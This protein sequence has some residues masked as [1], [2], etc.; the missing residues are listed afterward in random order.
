MEDVGSLSERVVTLIREA[1]QRYRR[2]F[3][4]VTRRAPRRFAERDWAGAMH[5]ARYRLELYGRVVDDLL[6]ELRPALGSRE[7]DE[8]LWAEMR[9][10][11]AEKI[12]G[13]PARQI[14][15]TFFNSIT[16]RIFATVG[17]NPRIE[18][19]DFRFTRVP[20]PYTDPPIRDYP[21]DGETTAAVRALLADYTLDAP[22]ADLDGDAERVAAEIDRHWQAADAPLPLQRLEILVPVFFRRKGAYLIGRARAG[23]RALP[24]VLAL[25]HEPEGVKVDAVLLVED[26]VSIVFSFT[27]SYFNVDT[28]RPSDVITFL[29][30][31]MPS[32]PVAE[33]YTSLG[34][35]KHGKTEFFRDLQRH[36][37]LSDERFVRAPGER[38]MVMAVFTIPSYEIVFKVIRD[39][40]PREKQTSRQTIRQR[41]RLV[42]THDRAG[43]LLDVQEFEH[44]SFELGRFDEDLL[45]E[46]LETAARNVRVEG[47]RVVIRH[48]YIQRR[49]RPLD[50]YMHA[51]DPLSAR[52][53]ALDFGGAIRELAATDVFPGD[54]LLKNFGVTR[55]GRVVFYDYDELSTLD[56][57]RFRV[58]PEPRTPEQEMAAE[59]W[60]S[61]RPEDV[62]PEE[63]ARFIPFSDDLRE[64]FFAAHGDLFD[65]EFWREM[66]AMHDAGEVVDL[67]PYREEL[68]LQG[69]MGDARGE[70]GVG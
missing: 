60:F 33:L 19:V 32:K 37:E 68:R 40:F 65:V 41:Y 22:W 48:L 18:F 12:A 46:L 44:L 3:L 30:T 47:D 64:E 9:R 55:H 25:V 7:R 13:Y 58:L 6:A 52:R 51:A 34:F 28:T 2:E 10:I 63:L 39:R 36:L 16:R 5:D 70:G 56:E 26:D 20:V 53:A 4:D 1:F 42:F 27:S 54:F 11:Y 31:L 67:Y 24:L 38:G 35:N 45:A 29:R 8:T 21:R 57:C 14:A 50:L 61:V 59:P 69:D 17:V 66:Q 43:R 62:F 49:V 23:E 15:E